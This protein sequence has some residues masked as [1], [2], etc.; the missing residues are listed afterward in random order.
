V[1]VMVEVMIDTTRVPLYFLRQEHVTQET[2]LRE[3]LQ[4]ANCDLWYHRKGGYLLVS[5][6]PMSLNEIEHWLD[7]NEAA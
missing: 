4:E 2:R 6:Y 7:H 5:K 3:R 1:S